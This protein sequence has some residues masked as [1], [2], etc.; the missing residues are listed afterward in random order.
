MR[1]ISRGDD[2]FMALVID[3]RYK[4]PGK[5]KDWKTE[6][7]MDPRPSYVVISQVL[8]YFFIT[9]YWRIEHLEDYGYPQMLDL[10]IIPRNW[11]VEE[12]SRVPAEVVL[13]GN[14]RVREIEKELDIIRGR[15]PTPIGYKIDKSK[16]K[17]LMAEL[18]NL[19]TAAGVA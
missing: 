2:L 9:D 19:R 6:I 5:Y 10:K 11:I 16:V 4:M 14:P 7:L 17:T 3:G 8:K 13:S 18:Q 12:G 15:V 1:F